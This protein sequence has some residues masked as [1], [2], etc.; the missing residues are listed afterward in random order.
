MKK[1]YPVFLEKTARE[2]ELSM[3]KLEKREAE[4]VASLGPGRVEELRALRTKELPPI[5]EAETKRHMGWQSR[6]L[7]WVRARLQRVRQKRVL[8]GRHTTAAIQYGEGSAEDPKNVQELK[9]K[10]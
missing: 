8:V 3:K 5:D 4:L 9:F 6:E 7:L 2:V 1:I 10:V